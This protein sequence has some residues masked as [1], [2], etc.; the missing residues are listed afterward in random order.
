MAHN[1]NEGTYLVT[2]DQ[3]DVTTVSSDLTRG[4]TQEGS[5]D[6]CTM[7]DEAGRVLQGLQDEGLFSR[8]V[9]SEKGHGHWTHT[10]EV[11][12]DGFSPSADAH[13]R[14]RLELALNGF[15]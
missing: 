2:S 1:H 3:A 13:I 5:P 4:Q 9:L 7:A 14:R 10:L 12:A 8:F 6:V 11:F 15:P